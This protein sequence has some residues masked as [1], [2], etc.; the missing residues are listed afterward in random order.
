MRFIYLTNSIT[1]DDYKT[2]LASSIHYS[3]PSNQNFHH[4]LITAF[5]SNY[6]VEVI[7][8]SYICNDFLLNSEEKHTF[9]YE[10]YVK[11][12]YLPVYKNKLS[13]YF[14]TKNALYSKISKLIKES[15]EETMI[16]VDAMNVLL[17]SLALR[18]GKSHKTKILGVITDNPNLITNMPKIAKNKL[19]SNFTKFDYYICLNEALNKL[20]NTKNKPCLIING[21]CYKC[22]EAQIM[23]NKEPYLFF[24]GA[25]YEKYGVK[26]LLHAFLNTS[27]Q[28]HL[29]IA[30]D[31]PLREYVV[32]KAIRSRR[33]KYLGTLSQAEIQ[34][35][36]NHAYANIN[37][38]PL[39]KDMD[40][41][42]I[43][44]KVIEYA[45]SDALTI[46]TM[47]TLLHSQ[48]ETSIMWTKDDDVSLRCTIEEA[49][50]LKS[51]LRT[52][53]IKKAHTTIK[54]NYSINAVSKKIDMFIKKISG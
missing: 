12:N 27:G 21:I 15:D 19:L 46:S 25:L 43:P 40:T 22:P 44:S 48:F 3:N 5:A 6:H 50:R 2:L 20:A 14:K 54:N 52:K 42:C 35:Y 16:V 26:H 9:A 47:H 24:A 7:S 33:I 13:N 30:G 36:E 8:S 41:Y 11:Y 18:F 34:A 38:R 37:P 10:N 51:S 32:K 45:S 23:S 53:I 4:A 28:Y 31:G 29:L 39:T 1:S 17:S 49:F